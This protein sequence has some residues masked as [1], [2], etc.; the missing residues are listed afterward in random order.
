MVLVC[1]HIG[2]VLTP[3]SSATDS[4]NSAGFSY[5]RV[6][7][8]ATDFSAN[9]LSAPQFFHKELTNRFTAYSYDDISGDTSLNDFNINAAP[10]GVFSILQDILSINHMARFHIVPWSPVFR[11]F[12]VF[13]NYSMLSPSPVG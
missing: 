5:I 13:I 12:G 10:S 6:P 11:L 3:S 7:L 8:G 1:L 9:S 4:A 2:D